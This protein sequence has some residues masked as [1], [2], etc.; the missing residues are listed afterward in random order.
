MGKVRQGPEFLLEPIQRICAGMTQGLKGDSEL[1]LPVVRLIDHPE[2]A[3]TNPPFDDEPIGAFELLMDEAHT[4]T[5]RRGTVAV[6]GKFR[7]LSRFVYGC[8]VR[9]AQHHD[10]AGQ[11]HQPD[12]PEATHRHPVVV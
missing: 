8:H 1:S 3:R 5:L 7:V 11:V 9:P 4:V 10:E 12:H 6:K 2:R